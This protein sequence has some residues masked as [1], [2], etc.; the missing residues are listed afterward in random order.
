VAFAASAPTENF[1][2]NK[3][4]LKYPNQPQGRRHIVT[5]GTFAKNIDDLLLIM[6]VLA[7][8]KTYPSAEI[9]DIDFDHSHWDGEQLTIAVSETINDIEIDNE[10]LSI[11]KGFIEKIKQ[12]EHHFN[13]EYPV[14]NEEKAYIACSEI[15][16]FEIGVNNPKVPLLSSFLYSFIRLKYKD[17]LWA[18]GMANGQRLSNTKYA[19]AID[20]KDEF[21]N[22]YHTFLSKNDIWITPVCAMEAYKH[23]KAGKPFTINNK[24]MG[25]TKA[26]ASFVFTTAFSGHPIVVI[27]IGKKKNGMP[28]GIQIHSKKW[29]DKK[30]LEIAKYFEGFT[31]GFV[32]PEI[33]ATVIQK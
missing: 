12:T 27:P 3:G 16:G 28:V 18:K 26:I 4:H 23:Q 17:H 25:Y 7:D 6:P 11:F 1:L 22:T 30:L 33:K 2:S 5:P 13:T 24:K 9:P 14:Y 32:A 8:N 15:I 29:T 10:Y 21:A 19:E 20:I 31:E